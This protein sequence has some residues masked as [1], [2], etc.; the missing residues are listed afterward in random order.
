[1]HFTDDLEKWKRVEMRLSAAVLSVYFLILSALNT[2]WSFYLVFPYLYIA[3]LFGIYNMRG[4]TPQIEN[5]ALAITVIFVGGYA[6]FRLDSWD[7]L[8]NI[9]SL[10]FG[11]PFWAILSLTIPYLLLFI[12]RRYFRKKKRISNNM[13]QQWTEF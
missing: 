13:V 3:I 9:D 12:V 2:Q 6:R 7:N 11:H 1:M 4:I 5:I 8:N 10:V